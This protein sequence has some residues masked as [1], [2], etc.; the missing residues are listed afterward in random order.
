LIQV[1]W[2]K[3]DL[4]TVD[5]GPLAAAAAAGPVLPL[6]VAEPDYWRL[7]DVS[8]RQWQATRDALSE[9]GQRLETLAAAQALGELCLQMVPE[10]A[11]AP[12]ALAD[13]LMQLGRL[14]ELVKERSERLEALAE[15][16]L[17]F[18]GMADLNAWLA[19]NA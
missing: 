7:P 10:Q 4:R 1:V 2:F 18:E 11:P 13:L 3:R 16:L 6:Y 17:D 5:H 9:L 8:R 19:A 15:A 12:G 14:E